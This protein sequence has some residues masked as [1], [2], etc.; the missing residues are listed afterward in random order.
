MVGYSDSTKDGGYLAGAWQT[1]RAQQMLAGAAAGAGI[2]LVIFHGRGGTVGRGGGPMGRAIL[3]RP[4]AARTPYLKVTEQGEVVFARYGDP[5]IAE[6]HFEQMIHASLL[7][8]ASRRQGNPAAENPGWVETM[9]RLAEASRVEYEAKVK[10]SPEMLEF[11]RK[12]TPFHELATLNLA[13]RPVSRAGNDD[14]P[15]SLDTLRAIPWV[16]SWTQARVNLPGWFGLGTALA[17]EIDADRLDVLR[18]MYRDWPFFTTTVDNAQ[19]SLATAD[20]STARRYA[21]LANSPDQFAVIEAEYARTVDAVLAITAQEELLERA[22]VLSRSI[23]LRNPYV[24]ALHLAQVTLLRRFRSLTPDASEE[25]R[26]ALTDAIHHSI[27]GIA[28]GLQSTG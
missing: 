14:G 7:S 1:N 9:G 27:N 12:S 6:R 16:F 24:D 15:L 11:F 19:I 26:A 13:S 10:Q 22:P 18:R 21:A 25:E 8:S 23:K 17:S 2:E 4:A 28:A 5:G 3:A 20:M